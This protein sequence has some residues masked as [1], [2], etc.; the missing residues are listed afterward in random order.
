MGLN[1]NVSYQKVIKSWLSKRNFLQFSLEISKNFSKNCSALFGRIRP[2]L[3]HQIF[4]ASL[5]FFRPLLSFLA[6]NSASGNTAR[7]AHLSDYH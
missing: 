3:G 4:P 7:G 1:L 2:K 5:I 6:G